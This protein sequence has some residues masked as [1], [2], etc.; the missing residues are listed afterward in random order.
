MPLT[1]RL[2]VPRTA[3]VLEEDFTTVLLLPVILTLLLPVT[4][5]IVSVASKKMAAPFF[6]PLVRLISES[7]ALSASTLMVRLG[8]TEVSFVPPMERLDLSITNIWLG[9]S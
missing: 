7:V 9:A 8:A 2:P 3:V 5:R 4:V 6:V 1:V